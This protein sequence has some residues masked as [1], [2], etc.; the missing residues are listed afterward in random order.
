MKLEGKTAI[1]TGSGRGI[2]RAIA[3]KLAAEGARLV[4]NDL[5]PGPAKETVELIAAAGGTAV[6]VP[7]SVTEHGFTDDLVA[8]A[9][10]TFGGLDIVVNNAGYTW[11]SVIQKTEDEQ[12]EAMLDIHLTAPFRLLRSA[13]PVMREAAKREAAEGRH[14]DHARSSTSPR[15]PA[16]AGTLARR[17]TRGQG[18]CHRADQDSRQGM[19]AVADHGQRRGLRTDQDAADRGPAGGDATIRINDRDIKVG[20]GA[21]LLEAMERG[22]PLGRAGTPEDAANAVVPLLLTR[23]RLHHRSGRGVRRR[24][25]AVNRG[26]ALMTNVIVA[27][28]RTPIGRPA[29]GWL[30]TPPRRLAPPQSR[31][32][33]N[34]PESIRPRLAPS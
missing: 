29:A 34:G 5:D 28:A 3:L 19:G 9:V 31:P 7:G 11:D 30:R 24:A 27:G 16:P 8:A 1:V 4:V 26:R 33:W 32:L 18:W 21:E 20:I 6:A 14:R 13:A 12:W 15:S 22:I 2:G 10:D 17:D 25:R 23:V